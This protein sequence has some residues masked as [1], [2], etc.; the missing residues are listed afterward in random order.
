M[1]FK[2]GSEP[3]SY[4]GLKPILLPYFM[5]LPLPAA[6]MADDHPGGRMIS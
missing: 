2:D 4:D 3:L 5:S 6:G 1:E